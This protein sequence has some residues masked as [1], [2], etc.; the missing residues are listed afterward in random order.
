MLIAGS[1]D[2]TWGESAEARAISGQIRHGIFVDFFVYL[3]FQAGIRFG[4]RS[5]CYSA[6]KNSGGTGGPDPPIMPGQP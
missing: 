3:N 5:P 4:F 6:G 2:A 1:R